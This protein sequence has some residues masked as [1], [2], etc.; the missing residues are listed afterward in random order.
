MRSARQLAAAFFLLIAASAGAAV[1]QRLNYQGKLADAS[2]NPVSGTHSFR[3][4][5][6][7]AE[8][9]GAALFSEDVSVG[10][11]INVVNGIYSVQIGSFTAGGIPY[12]VFDNQH[13]YLEI[14][15]AAG[16]SLA[17]AETLT[18]RERLNAA[19]WAVHALGA[20]R[21]GTAA[22]IATFTSAGNLIVP[23]GV[24]AAS[25]SLGALTASS[26][27]FTAMGGTQHAL[28]LSSGAIVTGGG[29]IVAAFFEGMHKG[30]GSRL[31]GVNDTLKV[32]KTGDT[33]TGD[34]T[35]D[36][37]TGNRNIMGQ[38][39]STPG[40]AGINLTVKA[41]G[42]AP[43]GASGANGGSLYLTG[44]TD[45][46]AGSTGG[47]VYV[48]G[49]NASGGV[50]TVSGNVYLGHNGALPI[51]KVGVGTVSPQAALHVAG[52]GASYANAFIVDTLA[53]GGGTIILGNDSGSG[54][55]VRIGVN[56]YL[57]SQAG[58]FGMD[59]TGTPLTF[60]V[61]GSEKL[62][63]ATDGRVGI[64][65][66][67]PQTT[68]D[69]SGSAQ[70]GNGALKSTFT[71][72]P[73]GA[74]YA[75]RLSSGLVVGNTGGV[76]AAFFSGVHTGDGSQLTGKVS[77]TG[78]FMTGQLTVIGSSIT[79][80]NTNVGGAGDSYSLAAGTSGVRA[81][82]HL[83][84]STMGQVDIYHPAFTVGGASFVVTGLGAAAGAS[85]PG[86]IGNNLSLA[87]RTIQVFHN[88]QNANLSIRSASTPGVWFE[89][90]LGF[91]NRR[92]WS[93]QVLTGQLAWR[94]FNEQTGALNQDGVLILTST[95][96]VGVGV[97]PQARLHVSS[98]TTAT[99]DNIVLVST[100]GAGTT[101]NLFRVQANGNVFAGGAFTGGGA[102]LAEMYRAEP[103]VEAGDV[104]EFAPDGRLRRATAASRR[105]MGVVSTSPGSL[106]GWDISR[107]EM[108]E[109][110]P[111][112]L[113]G[114]VPVRFTLEAGP[115]RRGD[116]LAAS[117]TPGAARRAVPGEPAVAVALEDLD[118]AGSVLAYVRGA[119]PAARAEL[120]AL[121]AQNEQLRRDLDELRRAVKAQGG[122]R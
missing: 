80:I 112:A 118:A 58:R 15:V 92:L 106:L 95:G 31:S 77:K 86:F 104:V 4:K 61:S 42:A 85:A 73:G 14:D 111:L 28:R 41:G 67:T 122:A 117:S 51:G 75:L 76:V 59:S 62:R 71:A 22:V 121:K 17:S 74:T 19:A 49:A 82:Y 48:Y 50:S 40:A 54:D 109:H 107:T 97:N 43:S 68:L 52:G 108:P 110:R 25:A 96:A 38:D 102:D 89:T 116:A 113:A 1:P 18:P 9:G 46:G 20:E 36:Y 60:E 33:M 13:L 91:A 78:D 66:T 16:I 83:V 103:D 2:G 12:G 63:V 64:A 101:T 119:D 26:G 65:T 94:N 23:F 105:V 30:D 100:T 53:A 44:G 93:N 90:G 10:N 87:G 114:R 34:L 99:T 39:Q 69:V 72:T 11:A 84:V 7:A 27:T 47:S 115:V 45:D 32:S 56:G 29:G 57:R 79:A 88:Q 81:S 3:F 8:T 55:Q 5:L 120:D 6:F 21:L 35:F 37:N 98:G 24:N 70:F